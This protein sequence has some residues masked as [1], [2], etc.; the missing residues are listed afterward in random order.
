MSKNVFEVER[1]ALSVLRTE[2]FTTKSPIEIIWKDL[3]FLF[4]EKISSHAIVK[5]AI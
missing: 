5:C 2:V 3:I 1:H 4:K